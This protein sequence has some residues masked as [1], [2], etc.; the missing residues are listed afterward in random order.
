MISRKPM[1]LDFESWRASCIYLCRLKLSRGFWTRELKSMTPGCG[2]AQSTRMSQFISMRDI[3]SCRISF[4]Y[5]V[6]VQILPNP[7]S[8]RCKKNNW[9]VNAHKDEGVH[10]V[11]VNSLRKPAA[12]V[13]AL[14]IYIFKARG[15]KVPAQA[16]AVVTVPRPRVTIHHPS[17]FPATSVGAQHVWDGSRWKSFATSTFMT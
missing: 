15:Y 5:Q 7:R 13:L 8:W 1:Q 11:S 17:P 2:H 16:G 10:E 14:F 12:S 3:V 9:E 4:H 6:L